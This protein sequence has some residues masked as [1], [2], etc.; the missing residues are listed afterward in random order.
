M[1]SIRAW[2][3]T[4]A[5]PINFF[6]SFIVP[7]ILPKSLA[8]TIQPDPLHAHEPFAARAA[9]SIDKQRPICSI[10][11]P[12]ARPSAAS[13]APLFLFLNPNA[14]DEAVDE[15][16]ASGIHPTATAGLDRPWQ[17]IPDS[18]PPSTDLARRPHLQQS[19]GSKA[20]DHVRIRE[21]FPLRNGRA[22]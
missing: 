9:P 4:D 14:D 12:S 8:S 19:T 7:S 3:N 20:E 16:M 22:C 6:Q 17:S 21:K 1:G 13:A 5:N 15:A 11:Y 18:S 10:L 2:I